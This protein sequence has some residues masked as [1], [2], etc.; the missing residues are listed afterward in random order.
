[1]STSESQLAVLVVDD[2]PGIRTSL[3]RILRHDGFRVDVAASAQEAMNRVNWQ[4]YFAILLDRRLPDGSADELLP[5][6]VECAPDAAVLIITAFGDWES[7][8]SAIRTGATDY[9]LKPVDPTELRMRLHMLADLSLAQDEVR[10]R[11][12]QM[13]F[14]I[15]HLPA[16]AVYV[17]NITGM[18]R[19]NATVERLT[20]FSALELP[21]RDSWFEKLFGSS[22]AEYQ[23][24][25]YE[26]RASGF[27]RQRILKI[28]AKDNR[29]ILTEFNGYNY[30]DH[31]VW[32][33]Y[34]VTERIRAQEE[35]RQQRDFSARLLETAQVIVLVLSP[36]AKVI[37]FNQFMQ[38]LVGYQL[39]EVVGQD[40]FQLFIPEGDVPQICGLFQ[41]VVQ[42]EEVQGHI[43]SIQTREGKTRQIAWSAKTLCDPNGQVTEVL[44][45]GHDITD[46]KEMQDKLVQTERLAAIGQMIAGLAHESRNALQRARACLDML[47]L[48]LSD[49]PRQIELTGRIE[50]ALEELQRLY[51]E[52]RTYAAPVKLS[53]GRCDLQDIWRMSWQHV[54]Q[55]H[56]PVEVSL[57]ASV[58]DVD[59]ICLAD[60]H[61]LEQVFRNVFE[62]AVSVSP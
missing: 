24:Q 4:D 40:W 21:N 47:S 25:Y 58:G 61:R 46:L 48:D 13:Q 34:D 3:A 22:G 18:M 39:E 55:A 38:D 51:E 45:I 14:M 16:G 29:E 5:Q 6:V 2:D 12:R 10:R 54:V 57:S 11:D 19:V 28:K 36:D 42:G 37:R 33:I 30:D 7:T 41:R 59:T 62:N 53:L 20:G 31:E 27:N 44:A 26:D 52:V 60:S 17:D 50:T 43:N 9:L 56:N 35:L 1:M 23:R 15:E 8:L 49:Q 32:M